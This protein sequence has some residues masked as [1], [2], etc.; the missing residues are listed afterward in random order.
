VEASDV[1]A[2]HSGAKEFLG[3]VQVG[4]TIGLTVGSWTCNH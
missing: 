4:Q 1:G 2:F 3:L